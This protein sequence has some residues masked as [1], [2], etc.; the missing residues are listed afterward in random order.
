MLRTPIARMLAPAALAHAWSIALSLDASVSALGDVAC[1][2]DVAPNP[3][4]D[5]I[6]NTDD[7][8]GLIGAFGSSNCHYDF[9][10]APPIPPY[11]GDGV[12][13]V[14]DLVALIG[15][16]GPCPGSGGAAEIGACMIGGSYSCIAATRA[17]CAAAGGIGWQ[18]GACTGSYDDHIA[19]VFETNDC[20]RR[21][22]SLIGT[23]PNDADTDDDALLDGDETFIAV[24]DRLTI[25]LAAM[26]ADPLRKTVFLEVD[27]M[28]D[29][30][31][32]HKHRPTDAAVA[33]FQGAFAD[34]PVANPCPSSGDGFTLII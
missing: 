13:D 12:V 6:V 33:T 32:H 19:D 10:P 24:A 17:E 16:W 2:A 14:Q 30:P 27:W 4:G 26:G 23:N 15:A 18:P 9:A 1:P 25:D 21:C 28:E 20:R 29:N 5:G 22:G 34:A 31:S 11:G 3:I 8:V 7:L